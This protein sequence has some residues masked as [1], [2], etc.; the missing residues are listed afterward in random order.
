MS[1]SSSNE[2]D[3]MIQEFLDDD[4]DNEVLE[5]FQ[6]GPAGKTTVVS[7]F[8]NSSRAKGLSN[9]TTQQ[10]NQQKRYIMFHTV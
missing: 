5:V 3:S 6:P 9:V 4:D 7:S 2:L 8:N 10:T 1:A